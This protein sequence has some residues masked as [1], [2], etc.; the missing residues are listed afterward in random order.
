V[1]ALCEGSWPPKIPEWLRSP[2][3]AAERLCGHEEG[4]HR[5]EAAVQIVGLFLK[6]TGSGNSFRG[7]LTAL[8]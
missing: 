2:L 8:L 3:R 1:E 5:E 4:R 7:K 6:E